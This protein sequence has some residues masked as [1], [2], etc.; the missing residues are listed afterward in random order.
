MQMTSK[1]QVLKIARTIIGLCVAVGLIYFLY[2]KNLPRVVGWLITVAAMLFF[3]LSRRSGVYDNS[4]YFRRLSL[5]G[6]RKPLRDLGMAIICFI[7]TMVVAIA[8][9]IAVRDKELPDNNV[10][11]G[12]LAAAI[13]GGIAGFLYFIARVIGRVFYGPPRP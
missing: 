7:A 13:F 8:V 10:T 11:V 9:T 3:I 12:F 6:S 5:A 4:P 1:P 2:R